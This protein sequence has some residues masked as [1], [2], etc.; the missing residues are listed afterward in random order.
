MFHLP[1]DKNIPVHS[2]SSIFQNVTNSYKYYWFLSILKFIETN[3]S[4]LIDLE[5]IALQML[6][7][8]WY[9]L[10]FFKLSFGKQDGF[11]S[12]A[13]LINQ[14]IKI[15]NSAN[16]SS[17]YQQLNDNLT[18]E[19][20]KELTDKV[21]ILLR[22]VPYRFQRPFLYKETR[23]LKDRV[24]NQIIVKLA[25][26]NFNNQDAKIMYRY[27][28]DKAI[29]IQP[30]WYEYLLKNITILRGFIYW[31]LS[32]F[33]QKNNPNVAGITEKLFKPSARDLKK[34]VLLWNTFLELEKEARCIY[35][36][37]TLNKGNIS[38][39]HFIPWSFV[40]HD[41]NWNLLPTLKNINSSKGNNLPDLNI[42]LPKFTSLHYKVYNTIY[43][44]DVRR[45]K[46]LLEDYAII[47]RD[48]LVNISQYTTENFRIKLY[49]IIKPLHQTANNIGF[50]TGWIYSE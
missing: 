21:K 20:K 2:L 4:P 25:N 7:Y 1:E 9:P 35:S 43:S 19:E 10:D 18:H 50:K 22:W 8:V 31:E 33:L 5:E 48:D 49:E 26:D 14:K 28:E 46:D 15:D 45:K 24:V 11:K 37:K 38:I 36:N 39:D 6:S 16:S 40:V 29:Q 44:A 42:Y 17:L 27:Y 13:N 23:G 32:K 12:L 41:E 3:R 47:F 34:A 30:V